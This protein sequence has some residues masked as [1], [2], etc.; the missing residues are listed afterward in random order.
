MKKDITN[1]I[2][3]K[4]FVC[5]AQSNQYSSKRNYFFAFSNRIWSLVFHSNY[6]FFLFSAENLLNHFSTMNRFDIEHSVFFWTNRFHSFQISMDMRSY[7]QDKWPRSTCVIACIHTNSLHKNVAEQS[8]DSIHIFI[9]LYDVT[10]RSLQKSNTKW[11]AARIDKTFV[12]YQIHSSCDVWRREF[13]TT[14]RM[15]SISSVQMY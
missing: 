2:T 14:S 13:E 8:S 1:I 10:M 12:S 15:S 7:V 9:L 11:M 3:K 6:I 4:L 5:D